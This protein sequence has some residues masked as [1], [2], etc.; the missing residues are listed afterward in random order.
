V[1][2]SAVLIGITY[3]GMQRGCGQLSGPINDVKCMRQILCQR[4]GFPN[5]CILTLTGMLYI[6]F[7]T[8][9]VITDCPACHVS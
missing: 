1:A 5:E 2:R 3:A 6:S 9:V 7:P 4:F 8:A